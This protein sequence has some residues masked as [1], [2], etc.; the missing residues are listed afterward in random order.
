M[1]W[2][3]VVGVASVALALVLITRRHFDDEVAEW[4][5]RVRVLPWRWWLLGYP[6]AVLRIAFTWRR[7][8][9]NAGLSVNRRRQSRGGL[10]VGDMVV[11]A[12]SLRLLPPRLGLPCPTRQGLRVRV[13]LHPGQSPGPFLAAADAMAH[14]WRVH[15][16]RVTSPRRGEVLVTALAGN[17]LAVAA[18]AG[19]KRPARE[20]LS[21]QVGR[22]EDGGPWVVDLRRVPHWLVIGATRSG[23][24]NWLAALVRELAPQA[25][26]LV[27]I[28]CKGG[29]ELSLMA[30]RLSA[31]A[32]N[33]TEAADLLLGLVAEAEHRMQVCRAAGV[34][35]VWEMPV[36]AR[37]VPVVCVVDELAELYLTDGTA[38]S[39]R[40][41]VECSTALLRLAQLGAALGLHLVVAGQRFGS[42]LGP[43]VTALRAQLGG[44]ICHAVNDGTTA[45]MALG[46]LAPDAVAVAQSITEDEQGVAVTTVGARWMLARSTLV[47][48]E[49]SR[50]TAAKYAH[51]APE[52]PAPGRPGGGAAA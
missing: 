31:L 40:A 25:V 39:K 44:R 41:A 48:T 50:A 33:R 42:E 18:V 9:D 22:F 7:L 46:D 38:Q 2:S 24:S 23:K 20:L 30:A 19:G 21:A 32:T 14:A 8:A 34:R 37:P 45:E 3:L 1:P 52:F 49:E 51:M 17:P 43:G 5:A 16:V 26:A 35:S 12:R 15:A 47:T 28:D 6:V 29:M 27:G 4:W 36:T 13:R 10:V 11:A